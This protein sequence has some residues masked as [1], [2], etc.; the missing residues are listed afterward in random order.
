MRVSRF[1]KISAQVKACAKEDRLEDLGGGNYRI[2]VKS[3]PDEGRANIAVIRLIAAHF[4]VTR[5]R[6]TLK[7][8]QTAKFKIFVID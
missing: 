8:G 1:V 5:A 3:A 4:G 6:V 7:S 2:R